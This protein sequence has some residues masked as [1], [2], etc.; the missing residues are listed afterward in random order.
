MSR[1]FAI[2]EM[3]SLIAAAVFGIL[4]LRNSNNPFE[5][6]PYAFMATLVATTAAN[7]ARRKSDSGVA[8]SAMNN[9]AAQV[10][11]SFERQFV[12]ADSKLNHRLSSRSASTA[13]LLSPAYDFCKP[14]HGHLA[15]EVGSK[16]KGHLRHTRSTP[17]YQ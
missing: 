7:F 5:F 17:G 6:E 13:L 3:L 12:G 2:V 16:A 1:I 9:A 10:I 15:Q 4:W 14:L 8:L 11:S